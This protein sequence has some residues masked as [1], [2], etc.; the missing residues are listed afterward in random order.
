MKKIFLILFSS[1]TSVV[2]SPAILT[3]A[4]EVSLTNIDDSNVAETVEVAQ[5][6]TQTIPTAP[7]AGTERNT[8]A[9]S[10]IAQTKNYT[11]SVFSDTIVMNCENSICKTG[12]LV[13]AHNSAALLGNLSSI[14]I[15][16]I[17]TITENGVTTSYR[18][19]EKVTYAKTSDGYLENDPYLMGKI[20]NTAMGH[21]TALMTCA[22][23]SYG[24][25]DA[26]H[27]LV[28]YAD[29]I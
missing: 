3:A 6:T 13:Y 26:S 21:T 2:M 15:G 1:L 28:V 29:A 5:E 14:A 7:A 9:T 27:R 11:V 20:K 25:G 12:K 22:G 16:E 10:A 18:V 4:D 23:T 19:T 24:N 8:V 17:F